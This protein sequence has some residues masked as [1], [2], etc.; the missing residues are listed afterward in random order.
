MRLPGGSSDITVGF[1]VGVPLVSSYQSCA[2]CLPPVA[3]LL[4]MPRVVI[5]AD[6]SIT[7][8]SSAAGIP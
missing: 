6:I 3:N 2:P 8:G 7:I 5:D 1:D 4:V